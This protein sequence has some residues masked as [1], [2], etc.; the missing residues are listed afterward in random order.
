MENTVQPAVE[1]KERNFFE[2]WVGVYFSPRETFES[3]NRKPNWLIPLIALALISTFSVVIMSPVLKTA[4][5]NAIAER[6]GIS[7]DEAEELLQRGASIQ[8]YVVPLSSFVGVFV[9][10]LIIAGIFFLVGN[11]FMGGETSYKKVLSIYCYIAF[12]IGLVGTIIKVPLILAKKSMSVQTSLAA[13]LS[14][15][16]R[17]TFLYRLFSHFD[18]FTIW[19]MILMVIGMAV[20]YRFST[21][22]SA[23]LVGSLWLL[24]IVVSLLFKGIFGGGAFVG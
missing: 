1:E 24:W 18:I 13:L 11:Y 23:V 5:I 9:V 20:I 3:I 17:E 6:Q 12:A 21:K 10:T 15:D 4:Q 2:R 7:E 19:S 16:A 14:E 8:K 22:K